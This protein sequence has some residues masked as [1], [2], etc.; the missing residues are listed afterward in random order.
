MPKVISNYFEPFLGSGSVLFYVL[1]QQLGNKITIRNRIV[2][3]DFNKDLINFFKVLQRAPMELNTIFVNRF[4]FPFN[5]LKSKEA[6]K[7]FYYEIRRDFN[8][9]L[10]DHGVKHAARFLFLNKTCFGS[11]FRVNSN[12]FLMCRLEIE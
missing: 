9:N 12:G 6:K 8:L 10:G 5:R 2:A 4:V 11:L 3:S 1:R 7:F